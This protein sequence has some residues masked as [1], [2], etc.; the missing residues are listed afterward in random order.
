MSDVV[1]EQPA[2][3]EAALNHLVATGEKPATYAYDPPAGVPQRSGVY[4]TQRLNIVNARV[5]PPPGGLSLD[6]N[7]FELRQHASVL[8]DFKDPAAI[9]RIYYPESEALLRGWTGAKRAVIPITRFAT[10]M[11]RVPAPCA[12]RSSSF[13]TTRPSCRVRAACAIPCR[14]MKRKTAQ[15]EG[16]DRQ[17]VAS[18]RIDGRIV[19]AGV[20]RCAQYCA[21]RSGAVGSDLSGQSRRDLCVRVQP[22]ASLVLLSADEGGRS[23]AAENLRFRW[24]RC[25]A[26]D[27]TY[28]IR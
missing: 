3:V 9:E 23:P 8:S 28:G 24:R 17:P 5:S 14:R 16:G 19:A 15:G 27:S 1:I 21:D 6:R 26:A 13:T 2:V 10:A 18:H 4:R 11:R 7:G 20:E 12:S 25:R 22:E